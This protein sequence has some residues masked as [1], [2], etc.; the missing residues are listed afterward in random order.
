LLFL[1]IANL[2]LIAS[3]I[4]QLGLLEDCRV[5]LPFLGFAA[6]AESFRGTDEAEARVVHLLQCPPWALPG[7][8]LLYSLL[9]VAFTYFWFSGWPPVYSIDGGAFDWLFFLTALFIYVFFSILLLRF[10]LVW[11][12]THRLLRRLYWHPTRSSYDTLRAV[13]LPDRPEAQ[14]I[15]LVEPRPSLTAIEFCLQ[16]AREI[17]RVLERAAEKLTPPQSL[18]V[19][20]VPAYKN[21]A[22]TILRAE[23]ALS[24]VL[25]AHARHEWGEA[26]RKK[27][28]LQY[29]MTSLSSQI[30]ALLEPEWRMSAQGVSPGADA[31][32]GKLLKE[33]NLFVA[34]RVVDFIRQVFPQLRTLAG[35]AMG[36]VLAMMLAVS[37]YPFPRHNTLLWMSW[38]V[39]LSAVA[40]CLTVFVQMNR[41]RIISMLSGTEP[42]RFN[43]NSSFIARLLMYAIVPVLALAGAQ[44]PHALGG[45]FSWL[46]GLFGAGSR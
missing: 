16:R 18:S 3:D 25:A 35:F 44:Y 15:R 29:E 46:S 32:R 20:P 8:W 17:M 26:L 36:G 6:G 42:G 7:S 30:A 27:L 10:V 28:N 19:D 39:L 34:S 40:I 43:W 13:S 14:T 12:A 23:H 37:V 33:S 1:A 38:I 22:Q 24:V 2:C 21:L 9:L 31:L 45:V 4:W 41:S 5:D 11:T